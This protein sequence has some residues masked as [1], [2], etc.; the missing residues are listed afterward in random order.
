MYLVIILNFF[1]FFSNFG[2]F[3]RNYRNKLKKRGIRRNLSSHKREFANYFLFLC[4][5]TKLFD[6]LLVVLSTF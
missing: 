3:T 2:P 6:I 4:D 5:S 1:P